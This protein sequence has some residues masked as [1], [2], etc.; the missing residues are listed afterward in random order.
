[1][2]IKNIW[3]RHVLMISKDYREICSYKFNGNS[4]VNKLDIVFEF[5]I[6][7]QYYR[8]S[9]FNHIR[10]KFNS[11]DFTSFLEYQFSCDS[12]EEL[13]YRNLKIQKV[14]NDTFNSYIIDFLFLLFIYIWLS[15]GVFLTFS[16]SNL[17]EDLKILGYIFS[18]LYPVSILLL[19]MRSI[20]NMSGFV[21]NFTIE[22]KS[23]FSKK[24]KEIQENDSQII[25]FKG[26]PVEKFQRIKKI[27]EVFKTYD[28]LWT[29]SKSCL[30]ELN[31]FFQRSGFIKVESKHGRDSQKMR[32]N[33]LEQLFNIKIGR[34]TDITGKIASGILRNYESDQHFHQIVNKVMIECIEERRLK[35]EDKRLKKKNKIKVDS[36]LKK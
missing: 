27:N 31:Q 4:Y 9:I 17:T 2:K 13:E 24:L 12:Q 22:S 11:K 35:M 18:I 16:A 15:I 28:I 7:K 36:T 3:L 1:M 20:I 32:E 6:L 21:S 26:I 8:N 25:S 19:E 14:I 34:T 23:V 10:K 29:G 5:R 30:I 33:F